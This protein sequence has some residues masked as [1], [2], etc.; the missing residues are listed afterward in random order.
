ML[1][2]KGTKQK[3]YFGKNMKSNRHRKLWSDDEITMLNT[4]YPN[5]GAAEVGKILGRSTHAVHEK[6]AMLGVRYL[7]KKRVVK[8]TIVDCKEEAIA[9]GYCNYHYN[10]KRLNGEFKKLKTICVVGSCNR[11]AVHRGYCQKHYYSKLRKKEIQKVLIKWSEDEIAFLFK[12]FK[13]KGIKFVAKRLGRSYDAVRH[14]AAKLKIKVEKKSALCKMPGC[15]NKALFR[16]FCEKCRSLKDKHDITTICYNS[17]LSFQKDQC[18]I[19]LKTE[20]R[21]QNNKIQRLCV[22]HNHT[23]KEI[24]GLLCYNCN[25]GLG[26]LG[27]D[28]DKILDGLAKYKAARVIFE[29]KERKKYED[30]FLQR[31]DF[32]LIA[33]FGINLEEYNSLLKQQTYKCGICESSINTSTNF[34]HLVVDHLHG[35]W[36]CRLCGT[37]EKG[38]AKPKRCLVCNGK[39]NNFRCIIRGILCFKCNSGLGKLGD[40]LDKALINIK[41]YKDN[42]E[43][44][45]KIVGK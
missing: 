14:K 40:N 1:K 31:K 24:R 4:L 2:K 30:L 13:D 35:F 9:Q 12:N 3:D 18:G 17:L 38:K 23:T 45:R 21:Q 20:S 7:S 26:L 5:V 22:D 32:S 19:C 41:R 44:V 28:L 29:E 8:C 33:S 43:D 42:V 27:D 10:N 11:L 39:S 37:I 36:I 16:K 6:A 34:K 25:S 15:T